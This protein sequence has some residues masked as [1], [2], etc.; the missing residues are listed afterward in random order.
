LGGEFFVNPQILWRNPPSKVFRARFGK[1]PHFFERKKYGGLA[2]PNN[3]GEKKFFKLLGISPGPQ[4]N[5]FSN[6][7]RNPVPKEAP[8]LV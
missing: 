1:T 4:R 3:R 8:I 7:G 6:P 5:G 2:T